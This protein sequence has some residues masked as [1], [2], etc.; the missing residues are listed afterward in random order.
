M[1]LLSGYKPR[2]VA[3]SGVRFHHP[4]LTETILAERVLRLLAQNR[5][6][7]LRHGWFRILYQLFGNLVA[8]GSLLLLIHQPILDN[9]GLRA[10]LGTLGAL[11]LHCHGFVLLQA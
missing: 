4:Y 5:I 6:P 2:R 3:G 9:T 11:N 1:L 7:G 10:S 8:V